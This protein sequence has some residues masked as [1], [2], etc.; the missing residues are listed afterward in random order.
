LIAVVTGTVAI[1]GRAF[2]LLFGNYVPRATVAIAVCPSSVA[3][4]AGTCSF[5]FFGDVLFVI[6]VPVIAVGA[7]AIPIAGRTFIADLG[8]YLFCSCGGN[9]EKQNDYKGSIHIGT[10]PYSKNGTGRAIL[11]PL[12][13]S[14]A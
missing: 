7:F 10:P 14:P 6:A 2:V 8:D 11:P 5:H 13:K 4:T 3:I 1:P 9:T 12:G